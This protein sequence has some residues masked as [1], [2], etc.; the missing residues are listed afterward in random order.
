MKCHHLGRRYRTTTTLWP[1]VFKSSF[2]TPKSVGEVLDAFARYTSF[3][4]NYVE[5]FSIGQEASDLFGGEAIILVFIYLSSFTR[6]RILATTL[7]STN[8]FRIQYVFNFNLDG[9]RN[10]VMGLCVRF[11]ELLDDM[12]IGRYDW[13]RLHL[14]EY[15]EAVY[16]LDMIVFL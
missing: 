8:V 3:L 6:R 13:R 1:K 9:R 14:I 5:R 4:E 11:M 12:T 7:R 16:L 10:L 2:S 15:V